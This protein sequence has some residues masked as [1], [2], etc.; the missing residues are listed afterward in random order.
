MNCSVFPETWPRL[1]CNSIENQFSIAEKLANLHEVCC[2]PSVTYGYLRK[3]N[4]V[5]KKT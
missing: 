1:V 4:K 3:L 5:S 2:E